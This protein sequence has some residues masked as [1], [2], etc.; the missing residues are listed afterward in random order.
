M[1]I[2]DRIYLPKSV[3]ERSHPTTADNQSFSSEEDRKFV[4]S[5]E[6]YKV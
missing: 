5:L 1:G 3:D 4:Q 6:L 2:G